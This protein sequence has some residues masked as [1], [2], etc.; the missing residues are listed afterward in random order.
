MEK[1]LG[2]TSKEI[3]VS[4]D[5]LSIESIL[6]VTYSQP[7]ILGY[8]SSP[9]KMDILRPR[10][11]EKY[12]AVVFVTGGGFLASNKGSYIQQRLAIAE[13]GYVVASIE[14]RVAPA[15]VFP[16]ALEDVKAA[17]RF[18]RANSEKYNIDK[19]K[20]AV[21]G[22]SA[23]GYLSAFAGLTNGNRKFDKDDNLQENSDVQ[24]VVDIY[25]VSDLTKGDEALDKLGNSPQALWINGCPTFTNLNYNE[26]KRFLEAS[27]ISYIDKNKSIPPFLIMHGD[28]DTT[29]SP[30]QTRILHEALIK[31]GVDSTRYIVKDADHAGI[32][33]V[34]PK[35]VQIIIE[36]LDRVLK[37]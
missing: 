1:N 12:P 26:S 31:V 24:A 32:R 7:P 30:E 37:C 36:F 2:F 22:D 4:I 21:M 16:S 23:G 17:I 8:S 10:S 3:E 5:K 13:A 34:Q 28:A 25:G 9:L 19:S 18:L 11:D 33:W 20:I 29:V 15:S 35:I 27:P 14:Y 6:N